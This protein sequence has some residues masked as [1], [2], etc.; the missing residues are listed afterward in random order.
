M[1]PS[2]T[3]AGVSVALTVLRHPR[4]ERVN[5]SLPPQMSRILFPSN[6]GERVWSTVVVNIAAWTPGCPPL[7]PR[8]PLRAD[9]LGLVPRGSQRTSSCCQT[10]LFEG[11]PSRAFLPRRS[12]FYIN[13]I[14][15]DAEKSTLFEGSSGTAAPSV[16]VLR[17]DPRTL[18]IGATMPCEPP[19]WV[20]F[21]AS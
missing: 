17:C 14:R 6:L 4:A 2:P 3:I 11:G 8:S 13:I 7:L 15:H 5:I 18:L 20:C 10:F 16:L 9:A 12:T 1:P 19:D 21:T